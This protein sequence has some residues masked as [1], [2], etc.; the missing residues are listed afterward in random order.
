MIT[1]QSY[2]FPGIRPFGFEDAPVF[3]G[4]DDELDHLI[5]KIDLHPVTVL[6]GES[7]CGKTS[8]VNIALG[9]PKTN[10]LLKIHWR[11]AMAWNSEQTVVT[12]LTSRVDQEAGSWDKIAEK[13]RQ[14]FGLGLWLSLKNALLQQE[15]GRTGIVLVI[16]QF[17][18]FFFLAGEAAD[19]FK[20]AIAEVLQVRIPRRYQDWLLNNPEISDNDLKRWD[21]LADISLVLVIRSS[22]FA[23]LHQLSDAIP[24]IYRNPIELKNLS[25]IQA[26]SAITGP[27]GVSG[28]FASAPFSLTHDVLEILLQSL[29][30]VEGRISP[31]QLQILASSLE[32]AASTDGQVMNVDDAN[33]FIKSAMDRF[34]HQALKRLRPD[35]L[36]QALH[37]LEDLLILNNHRLLMDVEALSDS[38]LIPRTLME[39]LQQSSILQFS[40]N[41]LG[42][43]SCEISHDFFIPPILNYKA[44][45]S[46]HPPWKR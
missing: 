31:V 8:L 22:E 7:G 36:N 40:S 3:F 46:A 29:V 21:S 11:A 12:S 26:A 43:L 18:E 33:Y 1:N 4:R 42:R 10:H 16:D 32:L 39:E 20:V 37:L 14:E 19:G 24:A 30:D 17:E 41:H 25:V 28:S 34:Y 15:D 44:E 38:H 35:E 9:N 13:L 5:T 2:R 27:A 6:F 45:R 23:R